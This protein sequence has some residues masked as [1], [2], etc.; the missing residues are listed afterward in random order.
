MDANQLATK[1][2]LDA[3]LS[4][5]QQL[6]PAPAAAPASSDEYLTPEEVAKATRFSVRTVKKWI[7]EGKFGLN[8]KRVYLFALE[9]SPGLQ[10]IPKAALLAYGQSM[11][12]TVNDLKNKPQMSVAA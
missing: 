11:G 2:D 3:L 4:Q 12:F 10:R 6:L 5:I 1:G 7:H 9:F 8:G